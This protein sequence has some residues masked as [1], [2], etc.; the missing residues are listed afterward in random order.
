MKNFLKPQIYIKDKFSFTDE[1]LTEAL[2][3]L[4]LNF[5]CFVTYVEI[6]CEYI[7]T[8]TLFTEYKTFLNHLKTFK[9]I[10]IKDLDNLI[11]KRDSDFGFV[12]DMHF[13]LESLQ[14][15]SEIKSIKDKLKKHISKID[16]KIH[17]ANSYL[18]SVIDKL[19]KIKYVSFKDNILS[20]NDSSNEWLLMDNEK[21]VLHLYYHPLNTFQ[22]E[23]FNEISLK[24]AEK[25][26]SKV[27]NCG[28]VYFDDFIINSFANV[29]EE[30][31]IELKPFGK[32]Y[33][34]VFPTYNIEETKFIKSVIFDR[35]FEAGIV[36][37][38]SIKAK[39]CFRVTKLG[40]LLF[41]EV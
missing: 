41:E 10:E 32:S 1:E 22:Y 9:T 34:Y 2:I 23:N 6:D 7:E 21:K 15:P 13:V 26:I 30:R 38:G 28:Y 18:D 11:K 16:P 27:I 25:S 40:K 17:I 5:I 31:S 35:L 3:F 8:A 12:Q 20:K 4:E 33:K 37:I 36:S 19:I 24:E 14:K 39:D 29:S